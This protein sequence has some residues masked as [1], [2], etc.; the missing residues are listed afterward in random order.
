MDNFASLA[1]KSSKTKQK[2]SLREKL[3]FEMCDLNLK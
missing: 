3:Q 1:E 2:N